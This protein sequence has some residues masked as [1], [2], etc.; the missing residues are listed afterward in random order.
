MRLGSKKIARKA[1]DVL[2]ETLADFTDDQIAVR[3]LL[4]II[5]DRAF[6]LVLLLFAL[7]NCIPGP[8]GLGS[9]FGIPVV[10]F[11][12]QMACGRRA[13][14]LPQFVGRRSVRRE[15]L[16]AIAE[17]GRP[18]LQMLERVCKPRLFT[19]STRRAERLL[20]LVVTLFALGIC[21]PLP[22][23]N[24][25]PAVGVAIISLGLLEEDGLTILVGL[26]VGAIGLGVVVAV[27]LMTAAVVDLAFG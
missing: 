19:L 17:R 4:A 1:S 14:R 12:I 20:G 15:T 8:P 11:G 18:W 5:G 9:I 22:L 24:F 10:L 2:V 21:V 27:L 7:P 13:P 6:G 3:D 26:L 25:I 23:T 16:L